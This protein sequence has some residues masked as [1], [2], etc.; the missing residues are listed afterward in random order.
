MLLNNWNLLLLSLFNTI[1]LSAQCDV[2][3][4]IGADGTMYYHAEPAIL[5]K[6]NDKQ[7]MGSPITDKEQFYLVLSLLLSLKQSNQRN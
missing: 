4:K 2:Q 5:Y 3:T 1:S 6:N 7:L